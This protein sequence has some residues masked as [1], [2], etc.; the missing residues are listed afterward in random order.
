LLAQ[1]GSTLS[2]DPEMPPQQFEGTGI[3]HLLSI[4][5]ELAAAMVDFFRYRFVF[6]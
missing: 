4:S 1:E 5:R 6:K 2:S 3:A